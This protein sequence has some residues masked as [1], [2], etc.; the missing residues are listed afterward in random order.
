MS[1]EARTRKRRSPRS[2]EGT[3]RPADAWEAQLEPALVL[4][5]V[6][7]A[8]PVLVVVPVLATVLVLVLVNLLD[9]KDT[10]GT[11]MKARKHRCRSPQNQKDTTRLAHGRVALL[12]APVQ[13]VLV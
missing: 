7:V 3:T 10:P 5:P 2:R 11:R 13:A 1:R 8:V 9:A 6:L 4:V 12:A